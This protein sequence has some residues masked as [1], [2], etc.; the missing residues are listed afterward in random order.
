MNQHPF[1]T[2]L[3]KV[4]RN[5]KTAEEKAEFSSKLFEFDKIEEA[6]SEALRLDALLEKTVLLSRS[7][8]AY[9]GNRLAT[10]DVRHIMKE[11]IPVELGYTEQGWFCLRI[12]ALLPKKESGGTDYIR[13]FL[14]PAMMDFVEGKEIER[15]EKAVIIFR[16][17]YP[18]DRP[19]R[20]MRDH[21]NIEVNIV[22][23]II[24]VY[25]LCDDAPKYCSHYYTSAVSNSERTEV[26]VVPQS[27]FAKWLESEKT[28]PTE[29]VMLYENAP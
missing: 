16:H 7:L 19:E 13:Q 27:D 28:M 15:F 25:V 17:V 21:D 23:D 11:T 24:G 26:Y 1:L 4:I 29:G 8:P 12:P 14:Y 5:L 6:Y 22:S 10:E 20:L 2:T 18:A 3:N 9:T